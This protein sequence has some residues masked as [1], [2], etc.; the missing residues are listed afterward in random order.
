MNNNTYD[1]NYMNLITA[2]YEQAAEDYRKASKSV[3]ELSAEKVL[4]ETEKKKLSIDEA[5]RNE[6]ARFFDSDPYGM[7]PNM[8]PGEIVNKLD[9]QI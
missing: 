5:T 7:L 6:C 1:E 9:S 3:K 8:K 2:I 4:T